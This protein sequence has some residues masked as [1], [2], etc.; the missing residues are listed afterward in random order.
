V[1]HLEIGVC[2]YAMHVVLAAVMFA[3]F[4]PKKL[5]H[6]HERL[7]FALLW[8]VSLPVLGVLTL[9]G[10]IRRVRL[11]RAVARRKGSR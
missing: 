3:V 5:D 1:N 10:W 4:A 11:P 7:L 6:T 9:V 2:A 8:P